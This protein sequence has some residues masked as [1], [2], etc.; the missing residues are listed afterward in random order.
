MN[1]D[2]ELE[3]DLRRRLQEA[4]E[5]LHAS[6]GL[7]A[8]AERCGRR[9]LHQRRLAAVAGTAIALAA[10]MGGAMLLTPPPAI[11]TIDP[12]AP[13]DTAPPTDLVPPPAQTEA[14]ARA[15]AQAELAR[16][17]AAELEAQRR[18]A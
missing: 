11:P 16:R 6:P 4:T 13:G 14:D 15:R 5:G 9:R 17:R 10:V 3:T 1:H 12:A 18:D 2:T 7:W 8:E